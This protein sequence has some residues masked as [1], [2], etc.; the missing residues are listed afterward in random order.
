M[1]NNENGKKPKL[2]ESKDRAL[3][4]FFHPLALRLI[5]AELKRAQAECGRPN[6]NI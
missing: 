6:S 1:M 5:N 4:H 3:S 2:A